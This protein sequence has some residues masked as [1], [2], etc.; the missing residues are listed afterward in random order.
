[1]GLTEELA[2]IARAASATARV[3]EELAAVIPAE[4]SAG[5][6]VYLCAFAAPDGTTTWL[7]LDRAGTAIAGRRLV[8]D[9]VSI[10]ALCEVAEDAVG[11]DGKPPRLASPSYLEELGTA[12]R[13]LEAAMGEP[14]RSPFAEAM[15]LAVDSV[16][17][18]CRDVEAGYRGPLS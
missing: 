14:G 18:L 16:E 1:V 4:P 13:R 8:R 17:E 7:A 5:E 15:R 12:A 9:A 10:A 6:R 11:A 2:A 3:G